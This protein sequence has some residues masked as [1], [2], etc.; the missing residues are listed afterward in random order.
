MQELMDYFKKSIEEY[1]NKGFQE[2]LKLWK[3]RVKDE[4]TYISIDDIPFN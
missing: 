2:W 3:E 1:Y 4:D